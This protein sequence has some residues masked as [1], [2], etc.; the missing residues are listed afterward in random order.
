MGGINMTQTQKEKWI[1]NLWMFSAPL[2]AIFFAQLGMGVAWKPALL[3]MAYASCTAVADY[4]K[5]T[6]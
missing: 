1:R 4:L 6:K 3:V 2:L 5:K